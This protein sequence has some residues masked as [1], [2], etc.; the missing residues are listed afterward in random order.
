MNFFNKLKARRSTVGEQRTIEAP[1]TPEAAPA[2][3]Q[4]PTKPQIPVQSPGQTPAHT[5]S[6]STTS[7]P[8]GAVPLGANVPMEALQ[9]RVYHKEK[10]MGEAQ[11]TILAP[12][13]AVNGGESCGNLSSFH[14]GPL[15]VPASMAAGTS[16]L[17]A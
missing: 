8:I 4:Q 7:L 6:S 11:A 15:H 16:P 2:E 13:A 14:R 12:K 1:A 3:T 17:A 5:P 9:A 10:A